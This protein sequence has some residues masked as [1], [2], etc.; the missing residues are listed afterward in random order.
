MAD[1]SYND[2]AHVYRRMGFGG[3][4]KQIESLVARGRERAVDFLLN[5]ERINNFEV[6]DLLSRLTNP[7]RFSGQSIDVD[8]RVFTPFEIGMHRWWLTRLVMTRRPFEEKMTLFWHNYFATAIHKVPDRMMFTQNQL[9]RKYSL[10]RFDTLLLR[11]AKDPAMLIWL[12]GVSNVSGSPNEN[13]A[14]E[15]Q[16]L[17]SMGIRDAVTGEPNYTEKDVQEIARAFT[18]WRFKSNRLNPNNL[19]FIVKENQHDNGLKEIYGT[20]ANYSGEDVIT[21]ICARRATARFLVKNLF[22]FFVYELDDSQ[23]DKAIIEKFADVY[24]QSDH[25]IKA[26]VRAILVSDEFF[27]ERAR[28]AL[29][30][31]PVDYVIGALRQLEVTFDVS[32]HQWSNYFSYTGWRGMGFDLFNPVDVNGWA[33]NMGWM[34]TSTIL[35]RFNMANHLTTSR[36]P[37]LGITSQRLKTFVRPT[38]EETVQSFLHALGPLTLDAES[39]QMLVNYLQTDDEGNAVEFKSSDETIDKTVR[40]LVYLILCMPEFQVN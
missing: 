40:G 32:S 20:S 4:R 9:L 11:V 24:M 17:F 18:G 39:L 38:A 10:A 16:E 3:T 34:N 5:Y 23:E 14:R 33:L 29:I 1:F 15:L 31:T 19:K 22:E 28:F 37:L 35:E 26:L 25:S 36:S 7:E 27:S 12:D 8:G 21:V 2:A 6:E 30:K 13:F